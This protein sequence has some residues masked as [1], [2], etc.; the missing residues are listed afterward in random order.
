MPQQV[1]DAIMRL[2]ERNLAADEML[3]AAAGER[4]ELLR[5]ISR[6]QD[7]IAEALQNLAQ[8]LHRPTERTGPRN[9]G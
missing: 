3:A 1:A 8:S 2:E 9:R 7:R 6:N 5:Q 4:N